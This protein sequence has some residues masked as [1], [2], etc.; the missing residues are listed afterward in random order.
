MCYY[1][2]SLRRIEMNTPLVVKIIQDSANF[3]RNGVANYC[4]RQSKR[5]C[6]E[7]RQSETHL[8]NCVEL[9]QS[10]T[11]R[12][13]VRMWWDGLRQSK[14]LRQEL[15]RYRTWS[16]V[17]WIKTVPTVC[18]QLFCEWR[19]FWPH[20]HFQSGWHPLRQSKYLQ[21]NESI[22]CIGQND[23]RMTLFCTSFPNYKTNYFF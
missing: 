12:E 22:S 16:H 14:Q 5:L 9:R 15:R 8:N 17:W 20:L 4:Q 19:V 2:K 6:D 21:S 23:C 11:V 10:G 18:E 7:L 13:I 3:P 1:R